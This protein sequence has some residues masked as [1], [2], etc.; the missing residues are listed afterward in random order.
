MAPRSHIEKLEPL[1]RQYPPDLSVF[2]E[3]LL[4]SDAGSSGGLYLLCLSQPISP[5]PYW[6][7]LLM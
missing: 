2:E 5:C 4:G 3:R 6:T 7:D 1:L